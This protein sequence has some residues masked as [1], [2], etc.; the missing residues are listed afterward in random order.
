MKKVNVTICTGQNC[1]TKGA[2]LF[3]QLNI[4][5]GSHLRNN[6]DLTGSEC[7]GYCAECRGSQAPCASVNGRLITK[8]RPAEV[9]LATRECLA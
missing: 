8:A 1:Y 5:M 4:M 3:K 2:T 7:P 6:T 9:L